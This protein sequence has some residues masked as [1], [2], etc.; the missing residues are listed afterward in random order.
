[1]RCEKCNG[2]ELKMI[3]GIAKQRRTA[4]RR[5]AQIN[6]MR[7]TI[8]EQAYL[9]KQLREV[10]DGTADSIETLTSGNASHKRGSLLTVLRYWAN[11]V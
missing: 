8:K 2:F 4:Q 11:E 7:N 1:M 9:I 3:H 5:K 6:E 10:I